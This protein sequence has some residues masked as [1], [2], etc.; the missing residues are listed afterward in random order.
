MLVL[1]RSNASQGGGTNRWPAELHRAGRL[2]QLR[3]GESVYAEGDDA[4]GVYFLVA[5]GLKLVRRT[6]S[7][8]DFILDL[9]WPGGVFGEEGAL[10]GRRRLARALAL[11]DSRFLHVTRSSL[12]ELFRSSPMVAFDLLE[13][14]AR[15]QGA[16]FERMLE[17][18]WPKPADRIA[19]AHERLSDLVGGG[20]EGARVAV[21]D[22]AAHACAS[23]HAVR[24]HL[25]SGNDVST[26]AV[27]DA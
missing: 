8:G 27:D 19:S 15:R 17:L 10:A 12:S 21:A 16:I 2:L 5:G 23:T 9:V 3:R 6:P 13:R 4:D 14:M 7:R 24:T 26:Y 11:S 18:T 20:A 22:V 1:E 25:A